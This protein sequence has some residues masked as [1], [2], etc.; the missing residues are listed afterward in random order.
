MKTKVYLMGF[1]AVFAILTGCAEKGADGDLERGNYGI[2]TPGEPSEGDTMKIKESG[3][4]EGLSAELERQILQDYVSHH[5]ASFGTPS[6]PPVPLTEDEI[7][8]AEYFGTY[9]NCVVMSVRGNWGYAGVAWVKDIAG[10]R[11]GHGDLGKVP[12]T[13]KD[14][15]FNT[16]EDAYDQGWLTKDDIR[17]IAEYLTSEAITE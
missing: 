12:I 16:L 7:W 17:S 9:N 14:G 11:F 5:N 3:T 2:I 4:F 6:G 8:V 10:I 15:S 1:L 13:W